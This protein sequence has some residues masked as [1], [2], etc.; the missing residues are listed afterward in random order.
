MNY[1]FLIENVEVKVTNHIPDVSPVLLEQPGLKANDHQFWINVKDVGEFYAENGNLVL[2]QPSE[3]AKTNL[4]NLYLNGS[5]L[6]AILQQRCV[7][8]F[9]GSSFSYDGHGIVICGKSGFGKSTLAYAVS[10]QLK[11]PMLTDD[12]TP[13]INTEIIP[14]GEKLKFTLQSAQYFSIAKEEMDQIDD[15]YDKFF[16]S[17]NADGKPTV[18]KTIYIGEESDSLGFNEVIGG[19]KLLLLLKNQYWQELNAIS[20]RQRTCIFNVISELSKSVRVFIFTKP[21]SYP[22][23]LSSDALTAHILDHV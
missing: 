17:L 19:D 7:A 8:A 21:K 5:I 11:C 2:I 10:Q 3:L 4:I 15:D 20:E 12:I 6:G 13:I 16:V 14:I 1:S 22:I 18:L 9:H 23:N